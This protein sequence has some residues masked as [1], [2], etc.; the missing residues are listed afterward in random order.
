M[1]NAANVVE[2]IRRAIPSGC[3]VTRCRKEGCSVSLKD[4]PS[5]RVIIDLDRPQA[6]VGQTEKRCDYIFIGAPSSAWVAPME[7][8]VAPMELKRGKPNASEIV[9][10]LQAGADIADKIVPRDAKVQLR[11]IAVFGGRVVANE[12]RMFAKR[13]TR[14]RFRNRTIKIEL[15]R[16]GKQLVDVLKRAE[17]R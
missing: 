6:P 16:C 13:T 17:T 4:A 11:P 9:P 2:E 8:R 3:V 15:L 5:P 12:L 7:P 14:I 1:T 10:Q